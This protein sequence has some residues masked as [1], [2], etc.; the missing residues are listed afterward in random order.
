MHDRRSGCRGLE[1]M[2]QQATGKIGRGDEAPVGTGSHR[3][4]DAEMIRGQ[5]LRSPRLEWIVESEMPNLDLLTGGRYEHR[6]RNPAPT[7]GRQ[8]ARRRSGA[9]RCG[10][11]VAVSFPF[12]GCQFDR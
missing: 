1:V 11:N 9:E 2:D 7:H 12:G 8:R 3:Q 5:T 6:Q 10:A 4:D